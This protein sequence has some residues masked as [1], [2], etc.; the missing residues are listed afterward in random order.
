MSPTS[1]PSVTSAKALVVSYSSDS[2]DIRALLTEVRQLRQDFEVSLTRMESAEILRSRFE[3]QE[4]AVSRASQH[5]DDVRSKLAE[6][7]VVQRSEASEIK[8]F[9][10]APNTGDNAAQLEAALNRAKADL[11]AST[12]VA[13]QR[14]STATDAELQLRTEQG[15]RSS[16]EALLDELGEKTAGPFEQPGS[17]AIRS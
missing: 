8:H 5:L 4:V 13:Q 6:V 7:Q 17:R 14:Q 10:E 15:K 9:E 2:G 1:P 11:E 12:N 3:I 16:L